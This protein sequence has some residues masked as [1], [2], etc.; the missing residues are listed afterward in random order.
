MVRCAASAAVPG[1]IRRRH[2]GARRAHSLRVSHRPA[3]VRRSPVRYL[4]NGDAHTFGVNWYANRWIKIQANLVRNTTLP[5]Q[6]PL[7]SQSA[8][9]RIVRF[10]S[11]CECH[12]TRQTIH[13]MLFVA[14]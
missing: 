1:R 13:R 2:R 8:W 7:P 9:S 3:G 12:T 10:H 14:A 6:G 11:S 5:E 4:G